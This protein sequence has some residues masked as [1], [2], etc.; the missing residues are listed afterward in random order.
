V[1]ER[2]HSGGRYQRSLRRL[3][4]LLA[5]TAL[6]T[7]GSRAADVT[8]D[9]NAT[10]VD[11][12]LETGFSVEVLADVTVNGSVSG[13]AIQA[14]TVWGL[15]NRGTIASTFAPHAA[16]RLSA[17]GSSVVNRG[18]ISSASTEA[19]VLA[20]GGAVTNQAGATITGPAT[21]NA[22]QIGT[23]TSGAGTVSNASTINGPTTLEFGGSVT[24]LSTGQ[25]LATTS[26]AN[27]VSVRRGDSRLVENYGLISSTGAGFAA[28]AILQNGA[29]TVNNY[30][31]ATIT[32]TYNGIYTTG[33]APLTLNNDGTISSTG[34]NA[35]AYAV[36]ASTDATIV[37]SGTIQSTSSAGIFLGGAGSITNTGT[38]SGSVRSIQF[39]SSDVAR[40]LILGTGSSLTGNVVGN[41]SANVAA[42]DTLRL[43]GTGSETL[44][45]FTNF[46][47]LSM[48]G[49]AWNLSGTGT[50]ATSATVSAGT[51]TVSDALTSPIISV[52]TP[53]TLTGT[54]TL[55]GAVSNS[56]RIAVGT[57]VLSISG[58]LVAN[59]GSVFEVGVTPAASGLLSITGTATLSGGTV[60]VRAA[61]GTYAPTFTYTI[62]TATA[63]VGGS[64]ASVDTDMIFLTPVLTYDANNVYLT[65]DRGLVSFASVGQTPNQRAA[66]AA[67][68]TLPTTNAMA[69]AL[70]TLDQ[71]A[72]PAAFDAVSGEIHAALPGALATDSRYPREAVM[73]V[74]EASFAALAPAA[75]PGARI[76]SSAYGGAGTIFGDGNAAPVS[77]RDGG[78]LFGADMLADDTLMGVFGGVGQL[79]ITVSDRA[80]SVEV[81]QYHLG[82][83]G[84]RA[85]D[86][87]RLKGGAS[88]SI[89]DIDTS[90]S[91]S[92]P[93]Y[94][95]MTSAAYASATTQVFGEVAYA[96]AMGDTLL[97]PFGRLTLVSVSGGQYAEAGG[98]AALAG[99]SAD[100]GLALA[101]LGVSASTLFELDNGMAVTARG[102]VALQQQFGTAPTAAHAF[103]GSD[104]FPVTGSGPG[105]TSV[106]L[107][108]G[109]SA[110]LSPSANLDLGYSG[111]IGGKGTTHAFK[112]TFSMRF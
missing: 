70:A 100:Y 47:V 89:N 96:V 73:S 105:G 42:I 43:Q 72:A 46:E 40:T 68:D 51:L 56:G 69:A 21:G 23:S 111:S 32:G 26:G 95:Q 12:D 39:G 91:I 55:L 38:I 98:D 61:A 102:R 2:F 76:W 81:T 87:W 45:R 54:G 106:L 52:A 17:A 59:A 66:G 82:V 110:E 75:A 35:F 28:G 41:T 67:L 44:S 64:F 34:P 9:S 20:G 18:T 101:E 112:A 85:I 62:L 8:I 83:Y 103:A 6:M 104:A 29:S 49:G 84:R 24:N 74:I 19:M 50:F 53:G 88:I 94:N 27:A 58:S 92:T 31:G 3:T 57:G 13:P 80:S 37:N 90:R 33:S 36:E 4:L 109:L 22:I 48:E 60:D 5:A 93:A 11:L 79:G 108:T 30:A 25:M 78:M 14:T 10:S 65:L 107:E 97:S 16:I 7:V 86:N 63:G 77:S 71:M 15:E 99:R 1:S